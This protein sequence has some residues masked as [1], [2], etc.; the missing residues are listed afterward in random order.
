EQGVHPSIVAVRSL[1]KGLRARLIGKR[2]VQDWRVVRHRP[3]ETDG[4]RTP[5]GANRSAKIHEIRLRLFGSFRCRE[6]TAAAQR[7]AAKSRLEPAAQLPDTRL[8]DDVDDEPSGV[9]VLSGE[10]VPGDVN[11]F[12]L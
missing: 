3:I 11:G 9:V 4:E 2:H 10:T 12:D 5:L 1:T 6:W 7:S 8:S